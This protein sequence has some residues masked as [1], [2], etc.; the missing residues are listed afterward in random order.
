MLRISEIL[1]YLKRPV[2]LPRDI[3]A[4]PETISKWKSEKKPNII[5]KSSYLMLGGV[6]LLALA[7]LIGIWALIKDKP[8]GKWISSVVGG[9]A[10]GGLGASFLPGL[11]GMIPDDASELAMYAGRTALDQIMDF[12]EDERRR[13]NDYT[14]GYMAT[15]S[16][17]M[18]RTYGQP[19]DL[20]DPHYLLDPDGNMPWLT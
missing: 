18:P 5:Q 14:T 8:V 19:R 12:E 6:G 20:S 1:Q 11:D 9:L 17:G 3:K 4:T 10:L 2:G 16:Y 7:L 13:R 15:G